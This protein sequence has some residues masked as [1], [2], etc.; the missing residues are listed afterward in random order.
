MRRIVVSP[1]VAG[2]NRAAAK[3][4]PVRAER[5]PSG[6]R[7]GFGSFRRGDAQ[8]ERNRGLQGRR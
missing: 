8:S 7:S 2:E 3:S 1:P 5:A 6:V 4:E